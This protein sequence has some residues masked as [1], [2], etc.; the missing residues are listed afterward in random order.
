MAVESAERPGAHAAESAAPAVP[1]G[2][3]GDGVGVTDDYLT[4][5]MLAAGL[6]NTLDRR[7]RAATGERVGRNGLLPASW[8]IG[9]GRM[10]WRCWQQGVEPPA[11]DMELLEWCTLPLSTWP[12]RLALSADDTESCLLVA[13]ELSAFAEQSARQSA[14][15]EADWIENQVYR[16]LRSAAVAAASA[17]GDR[18]DTGDA[19]YA[20]L[21]RRLIDY[22]VLTDRDV[23]RWEAELP[24]ADSTG[25]TFVRRL[26]DVAYVPREV[27]GAV[28]SWHCVGC[29]NQVAD[30]NG[31]CGTPGCLSCHAEKATHR[32]LAVVFEQHRGTRRF[33]HDPGLAEARIL[34]ALTNDSRLADRVRVTPYPQMDTLDVLVEF[35]DEDAQSRE[36]WGI[37]VKD[38]RSARLLGRGFSWPSGIACHRRFLAVARHRANQP[39]YIDDVTAELDGRVDGVEVVSEDQL[40]A[41]VRRRAG[42][43]TRGAG[44]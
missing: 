40:I 14:D 37:D 24:T 43:S 18:T 22:P 32:P 20:L 38:Q 12:V 5:S 13:A 16:A 35:L 25:Q 19:V 39:F 30:P 21:R 44:G 7:R 34:D 42:V 15:I 27:T 2:A 11:S 26:V 6:S 41:M 8:R 4:V 36:V 9:F 29:G 23:A 28:E 33:V 10:W 1:T 31:S 17:D 3:S